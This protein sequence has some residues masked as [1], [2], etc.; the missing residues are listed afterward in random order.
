MT[1]LGCKRGKMLNR[2]TKKSATKRVSSAPVIKAKDILKRRRHRPLLSASFKATRKWAPAIS[3]SS[4]VALI[5][6][7][8]FNHWMIMCTDLYWWGSSVSQSCRDN[9][10]RSLVRRYDS[11]KVCIR[12]WSYSCK[13][14]LAKLLFWLKSKS[15]LLWKLWQLWNS[16]SYINMITTTIWAVGLYILYKDALYYIYI[17]A[18]FL[19][20]TI[21]HHC[22][23]AWFCWVLGVWSEQG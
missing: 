19:Y 22:R 17:F 3:T 7:D 1:I 16:F 14:I 15:L 20:I 5:C 23:E 6:S 2:Q 18:V 11:F 12:L 21:I 4:W 8:Q 13:P 10:T 9:E